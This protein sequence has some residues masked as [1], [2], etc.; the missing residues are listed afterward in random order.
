MGCPVLHGHKWVVTKWVCFECNPIYQSP[1]KI[2]I[3]FQ[4]YTDDQM[5][6]YPCDSRH[7]DGQNFAPFPSG[8][9]SLEVTI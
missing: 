7:T 5:W 1:T 6:N 4:V 9:L 2:N 8:G 3:F